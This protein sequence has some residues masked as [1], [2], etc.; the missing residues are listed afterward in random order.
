MSNN[1]L[2]RPARPRSLVVAAGLLV[3]AVAATALNAVVAATAHTAGASH[4]FR[5]LQ[6]STFAGL[7]VLGILA[8]A[9]GWSLVRARA[10]NPGAVLRVLVPVVLAVSLVPDL[11]VGAAH[12]MAGVT[13]GAV[14]ALMVMHIVVTAVGVAT[15]TRILPLPARR[16]TPSR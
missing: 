3:A 8:G 15:Y 12:Q 5:P 6:L 13:W 16:W 10:A 7:T 4:D 11:L 9:A 2:A 14:I 1:T